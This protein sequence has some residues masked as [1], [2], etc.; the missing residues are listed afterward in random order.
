LELYIF[1]GLLKVATANMDTL[2]ALL[3]PKP[4]AMAEFSLTMIDAPDGPLSYDLEGSWVRVM[5]ASRFLI[6]VP[7]GGLFPQVSIIV[8]CVLNGS[9]A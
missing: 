6:L 1:L 3:I 9:V 7:T 8:N 5:R 4:T 2:L